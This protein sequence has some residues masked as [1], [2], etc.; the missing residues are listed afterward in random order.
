MGGVVMF[1]KLLETYPLVVSLSL[2]SSP[3]VIML[4]ERE[5]K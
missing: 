5:G 2:I 1:S 3:L 4:K